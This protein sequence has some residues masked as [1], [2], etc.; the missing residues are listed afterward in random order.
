MFL[1]LQLKKNKQAKKRGGYKVDFAHVWN[2]IDTK[3]KKSSFL[4]VS[5]L[6]LGFKVVCAMKRVQLTATPC[7]IPADVCLITTTLVMMKMYFLKKDAEVNITSCDLNY[8]S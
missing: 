3:S 4:I 5:I 8:C 7:M 2:N 6:F 1:K